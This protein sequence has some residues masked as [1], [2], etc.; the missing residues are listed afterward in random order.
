[1]PFK[2][3]IYCN[4]PLKVQ[5]ALNNSVH[6]C[7]TKQCLGS[8]YIVSHGVPMLFFKNYV[9]IFVVMNVGHINMGAQF[10]EG[11]STCSA[12]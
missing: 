2:N 8:M 4:V 10:L 1:M 7:Y 9:S 6:N 11:N 3:Y 5:F 12:T